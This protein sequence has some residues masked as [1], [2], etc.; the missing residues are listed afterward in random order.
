MK[1]WN[2]LLPSSHTDTFARDRLPP[3]DQLPVFMA[4]RPELDYPDVLN[5]AVELV[6]RHVREGRGERIALHGVSD[7]NKGGGD[8][9][10]TYAQLQDKS[11]RI[12][13]VLTQDMGLVP[14]NRILLRG[15]NSPMMAACLLGAL[16]A[17]LVAV[18]TMPLLRAGE[19]AQIIDKAQVS[20]AL[21]DSLLA[22]ELQH[23]MTPGHASHVPCLKQLVM[24]RSEAADGLEQRMQ[25]QAVPT[26][27]T[28]PAAMMC[29]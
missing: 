29:A 26:R 24:F 5:C 4:D 17:G 14:G 25:R 19:L 15:G 20:A 1:D 11:N 10:W 22:D 9:S 12:A 7:F 16:K 23:C 18:P 8:F 2:Q 3:Q 21:C 28:P 27:R 6:D 13:Q